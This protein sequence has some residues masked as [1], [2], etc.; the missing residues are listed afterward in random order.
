[1]HDYITATYS[2]KMLFFFLQHAPSANTHTHTFVAREPVDDVVEEILPPSLGPG[3]KEMAVVDEGVVTVLPAPQ[4]P[5]RPDDRLRRGIAAPRVLDLVQLP[6]GAEPKPVL[7][8]PGSG[9]PY[10]LNVI[11]AVVAAALVDP[12]PRSRRARHQRGLVDG[13]EG[14]FGDQVED[15]VSGIQLGGASDGGGVHGD[16]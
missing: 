6:K 14:G 9:V 8:N 1:M 13:P 10:D 15:V 12:A 7:V 3:G 5:P 2:T 16:T 4:P 11:I